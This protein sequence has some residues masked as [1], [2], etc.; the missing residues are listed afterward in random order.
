MFD[1]GQE[2]FFELFNKET[3]LYDNYIGEIIEITDKMITIKNIEINSNNIYGEQ[4][5]KLEDIKSCSCNY[6]YY[7]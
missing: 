1:I 3:N 2:I 5:I 7:D 6:V 4:V